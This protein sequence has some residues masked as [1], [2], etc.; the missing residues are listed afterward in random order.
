MGKAHNS[1]DVIPAN[2]G[3]QSND[4]S[5][6]RTHLVVLVEQCRAA[7]RFLRTLSGD[8]TYERYVDHLV[9]EHPER[10]PLARAEFH[11]LHVERKWGQVTRCC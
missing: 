10:A 8:D 4:M 9:H 5:A 2:A 6:Q 3:I 11:R 1:F 7:W